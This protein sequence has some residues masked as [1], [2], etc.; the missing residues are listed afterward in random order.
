MKDVLCLAG[1]HFV[2]NAVEKRLI[3]GFK[4]RRVAVFQLGN[5]IHLKGVAGLVAAHLEGNLLGFIKQRRCRREG[6]SGHNKHKNNDGNSQRFFNDRFHYCS[7][8]FFFVKFL[9]LI[10][11]NTPVPTAIATIPAAPA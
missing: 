11:K 10:N 1:L 4:G 8:L 5:L 9:F 6:N 3:G 7:L 2:C